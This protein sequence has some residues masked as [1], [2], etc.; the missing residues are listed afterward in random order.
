MTG[1][2]KVSQ[3]M[4]TQKVIGVVEVYF[5]GD[6]IALL[7][8]RPRKA[9]WRS[10]SLPSIAVLGGQEVMLR[11]RGL[12]VRQ[13]VLDPPPPP[14]ANVRSQSAEAPPNLFSWWSGLHWAS[15]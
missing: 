6:A 7:W 1:V 8:L 15:R 12:V 9:D 3:A 2:P 13:T 10:A 14:V 5:D 4:L 11:S